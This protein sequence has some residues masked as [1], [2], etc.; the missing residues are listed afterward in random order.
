L[1]YDDS[2]YAQISERQVKRQCDHAVIALERLG[3]KVSLGLA[4]KP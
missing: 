4:A 1:P 3:F 2:R